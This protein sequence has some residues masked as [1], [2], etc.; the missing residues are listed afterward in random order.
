[1]PYVNVV[2]ELNTRSV[3]ENKIIEL[4]SIDFYVI[5][6]VAC[7]ISAG[8]LNAFNKSYE[9]IM[10]LGLTYNSLSIYRR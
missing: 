10:L 4:R 9:N 7:F 5:M 3:V 1:M 2:V 6:A 8:V